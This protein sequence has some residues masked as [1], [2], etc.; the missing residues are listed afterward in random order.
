M[1]KAKGF[2]DPE[3]TP[4]P[5]LC[6]PTCVPEVSACT[7]ASQR[8]CCVE[9]FAHTVSNTLPWICFFISLLC[10][11]ICPAMPVGDH[12]ADLPFHAIFK[13][14]CQISVFS[15]LLQLIQV[16][17]QFLADRLLAIFSNK[18]YRFLH[19][20]FV[21]K[22]RYRLHRRKHARRQF[23]KKRSQRFG[24]QFLLVWL[25]VALPFWN[26]STP[27]VASKTK[28]RFVVFSQ[29]RSNESPAIC[30]FVFPHN[31]PFRDVPEIA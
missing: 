11:F 22:R 28:S 13:D 7:V 21:K 5:R 20:H 27:F 26:M 12:K 30:H 25:M 10:G 15:L 24:K 19:C 9:H 17:C 6:M 1:G 29:D 23:D 14:I 16:C 4:A 31:G 2:F 8:M 3:E 18:R